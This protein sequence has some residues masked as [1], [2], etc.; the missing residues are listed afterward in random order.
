M[1]GDTS[2]Y[3][4]Q[5]GEAESEAFLA[6]FGPSIPACSVARSRE[7]QRKPPANSAARRVLVAAERLRHFAI[8]AI[9]AA[10]DPCIGWHRALPCSLSAMV[11]AA[12]TSRRLAGLAPPFLRR[13]CRDRSESLLDSFQLR[14]ERDQPDLQVLQL[15]HDEIANRAPHVQTI[16]Q[17]VSA[18]DA[19]II[20]PRAELTWRVEVFAEYQ[21]R[22][23]P[24]SLLL[25]PFHRRSSR[26]H[27]TN[28]GAVAESPGDVVHGSPW[29]LSSHRVCSN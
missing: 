23:D 20:G 4:A 29:N 3:D 26:G 22:V 14:F 16:G 21:V 18:P 10:R 13:T 24:Q 19:V 2:D 6:D 25:H 15:W 17:Q 1:R 12:S 5:A 27:A 11:A 7:I 8:A 28:R 9:S